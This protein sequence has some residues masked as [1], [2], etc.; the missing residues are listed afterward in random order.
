MDS[1]VFGVV[2]P[3]G[4]TVVVVVA[5]SVTAVKL[6]Q[7]AAWRADSSSSSSAAA[8]SLSTRE[9]A[10]TRMLVY[11]SVLFLACIAPIS[12]FRTV[13]L[14]VPQLAS[15]GVYH[16]THFSI[17]WFSEI[18]SYVNS[19]FNVFIYLAMGSRYRDTLRGLLTGRTSGKN[20]SAAKAGT[21]PRLS[22]TA[23][24]TI[25]A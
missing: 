18:T 17:L 3:G 6:R 2:I 25:Q 8:A 1:V 12:M 7:V 24:S 4:V 23:V 9:I 19:S 15:G 20:C 14:F 21:L 16:N 13:L 11:T 10:V 5:T 22:R